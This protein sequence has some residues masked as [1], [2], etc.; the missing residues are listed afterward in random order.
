MG[1]FGRPVTE[2]SDLN[3]AVTHFASRAAEKLRK[4]GSCDSKGRPIAKP[5]EIPDECGVMVMTGER[6]EVIRNAPKR[7]IPDLPF[8][9]WMALAKARP[10]SIDSGFSS[11]E[12][13]QS[14]LTVQSGIPSD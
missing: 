3:E 7:G 9:M 10:L 2:L 4:Q 1:S 13:C 5:E 8:S 14:V 6:F 11:I 12:L